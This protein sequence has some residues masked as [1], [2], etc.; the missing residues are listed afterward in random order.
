M[1]IRIIIALLTLI[2]PLQ[3]SGCSGKQGHDRSS[4]LISMAEVNFTPSFMNG[5]CGNITQIDHEIGFLDTYQEYRRC[6][7]MAYRMNCMPNGSWTC[8]RNG[9]RWTA[10]KSSLSGLETWASSD[11]RERFLPSSAWIARKGL[12]SRIPWSP[13]W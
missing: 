11:C 3:F 12:P 1:N 7:L 8:M 6:R 2:P 9:T 5:C 4:L 13:D 10:L